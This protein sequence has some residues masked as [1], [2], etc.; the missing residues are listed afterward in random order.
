MARIQARRGAGSVRLNVSGRLRAAD[1]GRLEHACREAL[2]RQPLQLVLDLTRV[3]EIDQT[4]AAV[5]ER[6]RG[7]GA[8]VRR[9]DREHAEQQPAPTDGVSPTSRPI[10]PTG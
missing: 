2:T 9:S 10:T 8:Q 7:R 5:V 3:T 1:M 6:L 4:A